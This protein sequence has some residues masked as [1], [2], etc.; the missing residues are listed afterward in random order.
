MRHTIYSS[1]VDW[2]SVVEFVAPLLDQIDSWPMAGTPG[3]C[4]LDDSDPVKIA[5]LFDAARHWA[6]RVDTAQ[7]ALCQAGEAISAAEDWTGIAQARRNRAEWYAER[8]WA[9]RK[10]S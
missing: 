10:A 6:L 8:P 2:W 4:A 9:K 3:W 5:A 7:E 1:Q